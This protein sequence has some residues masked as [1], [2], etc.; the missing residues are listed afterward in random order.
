MVRLCNYLSRLPSFSKCITFVAAPK[1]EV[2][3][4]SIAWFPSMEEISSNLSH[5]FLSA[6]QSAARRL[7][8]KV[9][10]VAIPLKGHIFVTLVDKSVHRVMYQLPLSNMRAG[11]WWINTSKSHDSLPWSREEKG[12]EPFRESLAHIL[13]LS[14]LFQKSRCVSSPQSC[15]SAYPH[16]WE[17]ALPTVSAWLVK[18]AVCAGLNHCHIKGWKD[19]HTCIFICFQSVKTIYISKPL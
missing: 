5:I 10:S 6:S 1:L 8:E 13:G 19:S 3:H 4:H 11:E 16:R 14:Y 17:T 9:Q 2:Y 7:Q 18:G 12:K 15:R